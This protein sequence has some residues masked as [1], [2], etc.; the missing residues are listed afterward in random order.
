L[1]KLVFPLVFI[2]L[3]LVLA[4]SAMPAHASNATLNL[5]NCGG[6]GGSWT[7]ST[8]TCELNSPLFPYSSTFLL[9]Q[10]LQ[11]PSGTTLTID[12]S[13]SLDVFYGIINDGTINNYGVT[14]N[15]G[16]TGITLE[17][18][19]LDN[20]GV[21]NNY[22]DI[23]LQVLTLGT[24]VQSSANCYPTLRLLHLRRRELRQRRT[25]HQRA[26]RFF[27]RL[28]NDHPH[29]ACHRLRG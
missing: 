7:S 4:F 6:I 2:T 16:V 29:S 26:R 13:N 5:I 21:L 27:H 22:G 10:T 12:S 15:T 1:K 20:S 28:G 19:N 8:N 9:T 17:G 24:C 3:G 11:I 25:G 18:V 14:S 23:Y